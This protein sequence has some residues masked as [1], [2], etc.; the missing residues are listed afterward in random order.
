MRYIAKRCK[1]MRMYNEDDDTD[2][3]DEDEEEEEE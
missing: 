3:E 2:W 1:P